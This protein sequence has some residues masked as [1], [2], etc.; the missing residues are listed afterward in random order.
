MP[1]VYQAFN[2]GSLSLFIYFLPIIFELQ[3]FYLD[4]KSNQSTKHVMPMKVDRVTRR[5]FIFRRKKEEID[6]EGMVRTKTFQYKE[7]K[8]QKNVGKQRR[9]PWNGYNMLLKKVKAHIEH[10]IHCCFFCRRTRVI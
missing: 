8:L 2:A 6:Q 9:V 5:K 4:I 7:M 1:S 10:Q 3:Y